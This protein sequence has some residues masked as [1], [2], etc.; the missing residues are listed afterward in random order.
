MYEPK[1]TTLYQPTPERVQDLIELRD[2][3]EQKRAIES[4]IREVTARLDEIPSGTRVSLANPRLNLYRER[5]R[6]TPTIKDLPKV[7][8]HFLKPTLNK[9]LVNE[10]FRSTGE[11]PLGIDISIGMGNLVFRPGSRTPLNFIQKKEPQR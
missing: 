10:H 7:P 8:R 3:R 2:L 4:R 1:I 11:V 5:P 9:S 6:F